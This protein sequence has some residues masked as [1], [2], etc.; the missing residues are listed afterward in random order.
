MIAPEHPQA[1]VNAKKLRKSGDDL[2]FSTDAN[3]LFAKE[4]GDTWIAL[5]H[6]IP[7]SGGRMNRAI[8]PRLDGNP[9]GDSV[10]LQ[11][12]QG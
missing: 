12:V 4:G 9:Y 1:E 11:G 7:L 6:V 10:R 2:F 8:H 5:G 3:M